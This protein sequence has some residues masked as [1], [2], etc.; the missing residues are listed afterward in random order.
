[1]F[2]V[3][4]DMNFHSSKVVQIYQVSVWSP[5]ILNELSKLGVILSSL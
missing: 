1:M 3:F 4:F 5:N 2:Y